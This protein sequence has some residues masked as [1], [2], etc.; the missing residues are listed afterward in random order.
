MRK[1]LEDI[2]KAIATLKKIKKRKPGCASK[3]GRWGVQKDNCYET[4]L[5]PRFD[6]DI[7]CPACWAHRCIGYLED[8]AQ[9]L[10]DLWDV[11]L[12]QANVAKANWRNINQQIRRTQK[13]SGRICVDLQSGGTLLESLTAFAGCRTVRA[14]EA[15]SA[16]AA[17][18]SNILRLRGKHPF[19]ILGSLKP[20]KVESKCKLLELI[21]RR[22]I[23]FDARIQRLEAQGIRVYKTTWQDLP[24]LYWRCKTAEEAEAA[25]QANGEEQ[26]APNGPYGAQ[27][28]HGRAGGQGDLYADTVGGFRSGP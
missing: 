1:G 22:K 18:A 7:D 23:N 5:G 26:Q 24:A 11:D 8:A 17:E 14:G 20:V 19:R 25:Y 2:K 13:N 6:K 10:R 21:P 15:L 9:A 12:Y 3:Y 4:R 28:P 16:I 27:D